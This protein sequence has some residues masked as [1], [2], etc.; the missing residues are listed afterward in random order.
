MAALLAGDE[1]AQP[2]R[3]GRLIYIDPP[4]GNKA[5]YRTKITLPGVEAGAKAHGDRAVCLFRHLERR[6][7]LVPGRRLSRDTM[8]ELLAG[9]RLDLCASGLACGALRQV[10]DG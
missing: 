4:F 10:G 3:Q 5:D 9:Y 8:R 2:A 7:G 1:A 6:H